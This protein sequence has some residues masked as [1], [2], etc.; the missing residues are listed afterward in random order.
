MTINVYALTDDTGTVIKKVKK[1]V[2][3]CVT[4]TLQKR[5]IMFNV[6][7]ESAEGS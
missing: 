1:A 7:A 2:R 5:C 4:Y 6:Q 3:D